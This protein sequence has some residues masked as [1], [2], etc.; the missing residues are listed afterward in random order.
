MLYS[1][2]A[3]RGIEIVG[4]D[5]ATLGTLI[6]AYAN[7]G[8]D[9]IETLIVDAADGEVRL[10]PAGS[11]QEYD[12]EARRLK[13]GLSTSDASNADL[14]GDGIPVM[15]PIPGE[16]DDVV[17]HV[18]TKVTG[19][20]VQAKDGPVGQ[21]ADF[22]VDS[23]GMVV[24]FLVVDTRDWL[25]GADKLIPVNWVESVDWNRRRIYLRITQSKAKMCQRASAG[26][27]M[28]DRA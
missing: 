11:I 10:L 20:M 13:I 21:A 23:D 27:H 6:D 12:T 3:M 24:R 18:V 7:T 16:P 5:G 28:L 9:V 19:F 26:S 15:I 25:P 4:G 22:L 17:L 8:T 14:A 1:A 2:I